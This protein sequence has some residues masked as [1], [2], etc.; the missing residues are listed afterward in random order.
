MNMKDSVYNFLSEQISL[1][2]MKRDDKITEQFLAEQLNISRTPVREALFQLSSDDILEHEPRKGF[3]IKQYSKEDVE[4]YYEIIGL[5]DGKIASLTVD[6]L[7]EDDY[8]IMKFYIDAMYSAI[9]NELY[10]KYNE[11]QNKFHDVYIYKCENKKM[12]LEIIKLKKK[13]IGTDYSRIE[14]SKIKEELIV[15]NKE[16]EEILRM[17]IEK[18]KE[19]LR[20]YIEF[21]HWRKDKAALDN[22]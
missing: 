22:W 20:N 16:H 8:S 2:N 4:N 11:I 18:E 21:I 9:N 5:L 17:F 1:G 12:L 14:T 3:R 10:T 13:F 6:I 15:T 7:D 19:E